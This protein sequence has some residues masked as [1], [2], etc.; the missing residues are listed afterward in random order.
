MLCDVRFRFRGPQVCLLLP[1]LSK[2]PFRLLLN[3]LPLAGQFG[4]FF[5]CSSSSPVARRDKSAHLGIAPR[6]PSKERTLAFPLGARPRRS[7]PYR[8]HRCRSKPARARGPAPGSGP[9]ASRSR[10]AGRRGV[11]SSCCPCPW[12][13]SA[14]GRRRMNSRP[15]R[16][17][18]MATA[19]VSL[20]SNPILRVRSG[21]SSIS[22]L[23]CRSMLQTVLR[24]VVWRNYLSSLPMMVRRLRSRSL[25]SSSCPV[26]SLR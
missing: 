5:S 3:P 1:A 14:V 13:V 4:R 26:R 15:N 12:S 9:S 21:P 20:K 25:F 24:G 2:L 8:C 19:A 23:Y 22:S 18:V 7:P 11:R 6:H 17:K 16:T 10:S